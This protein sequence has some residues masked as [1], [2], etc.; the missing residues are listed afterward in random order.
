MAATAV[1]R[2][3]GPGRAVGHR[4]GED[5]RVVPV[6][7]QDRSSA[8][9][10]GGLVSTVED[11]LRLDQALYGE[12]LLPRAALEEAF[13][14]V[15]LADG[16]TGGYGYGWTVRRF[17]GLR[18]IAH[19][20]DIDG[21][22]GFL[23][24]YPTERF[25]VIVL[26]N[27]SMASSAPLPTAAELAHRIVATFLGDRLEAQPP[28]V[29]VDPAVLADYAG[30]YRLEGPPPLIAAMGET[31]TITAAGGRL[32]GRDR[33]GRDA[34]LRAESETVFASPDG[35]VTLTFVRDGEGQVTGL[36]VSLMG[37]REF[38]ARKVR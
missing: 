8:P 27:Y 17:R 13:A 21:F 33:G 29:A 30:D 20:G 9:A 26:A 23:A 15:R 24:R 36:V 6:A 28:S 5:G 37:L 22:N 25:T 3:S 18:E 38:R 4:I 11:L 14:P 35:P 32:L 7:P 31:I 1:D 10:A 34:E 19:G 12:A 16:R 2:G